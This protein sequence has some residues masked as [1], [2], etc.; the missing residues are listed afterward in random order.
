MV[1]PALEN[2][3]WRKLR[4]AVSGFYGESMILPNAGFGIFD[5]LLIDLMLTRPG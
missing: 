2:L 4:E 5:W 3:P 1:W